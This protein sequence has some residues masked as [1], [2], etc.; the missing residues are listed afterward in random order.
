MSTNVIG[1]PAGAGRPRRQ[2]I[3]HAI[4]GLIPA[5]ITIWLLAYVVTHHDA[6]IDFR[7]SFWT[8]GWRILHGGDPY[9]WTH[10]QIRGGVSFPYP[11][12]AGLLFAVFALLPN[13]AAALLF[14][15]GCLLSFG[16]ALWLMSIRD[17][18][19]YGVVA[20][21]SPVV[22]GWQTANLTLL[23]VV[24]VACAW[25]YRDRPLVAGV[26]T[27][28]LISLKPV[29]FP[30]ALWLLATRRYAAAGYALA[31]GLVLNAL[32]WLVLGLGEVSHWLHLLSVQG[33]LLYRK[34]YALI[35][36]AG[37]VGLAHSAGTVLEIIAGLAVGA[38]CVWLGRQG[39]EVGAFILAVVLMLVASPQVDLHYFA[40][41]VV[42]MTIVHRR[43]HWTWLLPLALW[44]CPASEAVLW[45]ATVWWLIVVALTLEM[46]FAAQRPAQL[47]V[48]P[49]AMAC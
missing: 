39:R 27:A 7:Q 25:R 22:I 44:I 45:Q 15:V 29:V 34:G 24:G 40:L 4:F 3:E 20:L 8:S 48:R 10:A 32:A 37:D 28:I 31:V 30:F 9:V 19:L 47:R 13:S 14:T 23:L 46:L 41:L 11:A 26:L 42:P 17:W 12:V 35:A 33:E 38:A 6:A 1:M 36:V 5:V 49:A 2:A 16:A 21:W 18:R 43:L